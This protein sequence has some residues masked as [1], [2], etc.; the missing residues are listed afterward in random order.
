MVSVYFC[1]LCVGE[2]GELTVEQAVDFLRKEW[3]LL[4]D[5]VVLT[6][7]VEVTSIRFEASQEK[8][9][10]ERLAGTYVVFPS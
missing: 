8:D 6:D 4:V 2:S 5:A 7:D 1:V 3:S 9:L 10:F